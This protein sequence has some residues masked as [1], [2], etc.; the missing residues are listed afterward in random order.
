MQRPQG[1][2]FLSFCTIQKLRG[3]QVCNQQA[4]GTRDSGHAQEENGLVSGFQDQRYPSVTKYR[5]EDDTGED[6]STLIYEILPPPLYK[7]RQ[8]PN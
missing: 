4:I 5:H 6:A 3:L 7:L 1:V 8:S 2:F